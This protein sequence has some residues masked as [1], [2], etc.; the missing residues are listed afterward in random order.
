MSRGDS[1]G[2][3]SN[4]KVESFEEIQKDFDV[5]PITPA[6]GGSVSDGDVVGN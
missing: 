3:F 2:G 5:K 6:F 1:F 4:F